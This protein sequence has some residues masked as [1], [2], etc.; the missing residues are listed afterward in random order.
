MSLAPVVGVDVTVRHLVEVVL[1]LLK[2]EFPEV[3]L[4]V[5]SRLDKVSFIMSMDNLS[6]ELLPA[7]VD[8]AEDKNW[9]V[10]LA[11]IAHIPLLARELGREFFQDNKKL[12]DLCIAWLRD[13]VYSIREAAI[14]NLKSLTEVFGVDW[15]KEHIVPQILALFDDSGNYLFRMTALYAIGIL[16]QVVGS[17]TVEESFM[18]TLV[19]RAPRDPVPNVRFCAAKTLNQVIPYVRQNVRESRIRPC[20]LSLVDGAEK[21]TDVRYFARQALNSLGACTS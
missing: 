15:T 17:E 16:A 2:D 19:E 14:V 11:I 3:R 1:A 12:G 9:R 18:A 10:R 6:Q 5:I 13:N 20:L 21:D 7:I 4:N 8:L